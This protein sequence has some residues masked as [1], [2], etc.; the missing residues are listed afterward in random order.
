MRQNTTEIESRIFLSGGI[1]DNDKKQE[2]SSD[3]FLLLP[4]MSSK[5]D[6]VTLIAPIPDSV[7]CH[8]STAQLFTGCTEFTL[9]KAA[10]MITISYSFGAFPSSHSTRTQATKLTCHWRMN[11]T[12]WKSGAAWISN[13]GGHVWISDYNNFTTLGSV[14]R[15]FTAAHFPAILQPIFTRQDLWMQIYFAYTITYQDH[16]VIRPSGERIMKDY[17]LIW[18][19][20]SLENTSASVQKTYMTAAT[21]KDKRVK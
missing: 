15:G 8:T 13:P 16:L 3:S 18:P 14:N 21:A 12:R 9:P 11:L 6:K 19:K 20:T 2:F 5:H 7:Q 10:K 4:I 17:G 1:S